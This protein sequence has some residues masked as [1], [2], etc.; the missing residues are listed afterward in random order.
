MER[1]RQLGTL[2]PLARGQVMA[3]VVG[4]IVLSLASMPQVRA[5]KGGEGGGDA[6]A[7]LRSF[8]GPEG[9][10]SLR[11]DMNPE[12]RLRAAMADGTTSLYE[13]TAD[14]TLTSSLPPL[15]KDF[16]VTGKCAGRRC[17]INGGGK[18][19][20]FVAQSA[21]L[22]LSG[23][24]LVG[25]KTVGKGVNAFE[26]D[27]SGGAVYVRDGVLTVKNCVFRR[28]KA[29]K[30]MG[31]GAIAML[32]TRF[33]ISDSELTGNS[34]DGSGGAIAAWSNSYGELR[35]TKLSGNKAGYYGGAANFREA[36]AK[37]TEC[38]F[39][40][41]HAGKN[42]GALLLSEAGGTVIASSRFERNSAPKGL[43]GALRVIAND[44]GPTVCASTTFTN[45]S[46][47]DKTTSDTS[48]EGGETTFC[49]APPAPGPSACSACK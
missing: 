34:V 28:N 5:G 4:S 32:D 20:G 38:E 44:D 30:A 41:N 25:M 12:R 46:A 15:S 14:V 42:G 27:T 24:D 17:V 48:V 26:Y 7:E 13:L 6:L 21:S 22:S 45:N 11:S 47:K 31:G 10:R 23:L 29:K 3:F 8:F 36:G 2:S 40:G 33:L 37:I 35:R 43:G 9:G 1:R 19:R 39:S 16:A 18:F 49:P